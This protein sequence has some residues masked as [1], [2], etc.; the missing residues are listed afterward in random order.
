M[1]E[2]QTPSKPNASENYILTQMLF[3]PHDM[4]GIGRYH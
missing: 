3:A 1:T 4:R 2:F